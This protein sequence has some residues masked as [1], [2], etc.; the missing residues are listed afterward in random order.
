CHRRVV[1]AFRATRRRGGVPA[2]APAPPQ[3][4]LAGLPMGWIGEHHGSLDLPLTDTPVLLEEPAGHIWFQQLEG[5]TL[6]QADGPG[7]R[8]PGA[9]QHAPCA[10]AAQVADESASHALTLA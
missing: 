4:A 9:D 6:V 3:S 8:S 5:M 1:R 10:Q 7:R 2:P